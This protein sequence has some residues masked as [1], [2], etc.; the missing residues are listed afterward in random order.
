MKSYSIKELAEIISAEVV[1]QSSGKIEEIYFDSRTIYQPRNAT[2][3]AFSDNR[4]LH[5]AYKKG[6]RVFVVSKVEDIFEDAVYL[7]VNSPL[8]ALQ[9]WANF[10][11]NQFDLSIIGITG[12]NGKTIVK[13]WLNQLLWKDFSIVRSPKSYNSQIGVPYS[14]LQINDEHNLGIFEAGISK[15][16]EPPCHQAQP[17]DRR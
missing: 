11:R 4:F 9:D 12:S 7:K 2:F 15:K 1:G 5:D 16:G 14:I 8:E 17:P 13:E 3:F 10:H 6:I